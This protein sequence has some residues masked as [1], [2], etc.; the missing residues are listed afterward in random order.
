MHH[1]YNQQ[2]HPVSVPNGAT[3]IS[4]WKNASADMHTKIPHYPKL[5]SE[6][7]AWFIY[8]SVYIFYAFKYVFTPAYGLCTYL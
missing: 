8:V 6:A 1:F 3:E 4:L 7:S 5:P 2:T